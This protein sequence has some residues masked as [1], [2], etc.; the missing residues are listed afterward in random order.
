MSRGSHNWFCPVKGDESYIAS[1][2]GQIQ[3]LIVVGTGAAGKPVNTNFAGM[4]NAYATLS[5]VGGE[6]FFQTG[7]AMGGAY[8]APDPG[9]VAAFS[10]IKPILGMRHSPR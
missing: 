3:D 10:A 5:R 9:Q 1:G 6:A 2:P 7:G 8:P 4:D